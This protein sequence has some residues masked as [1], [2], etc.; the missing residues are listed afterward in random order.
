MNFNLK[1]LRATLKA[2]LLTHAE[3][4]KKTLNKRLRVLHFSK[5]PKLLEKQKK[6]LYSY[7][8]QYFYRIY[9]KTPHNTA[10][11]RNALNCIQPCLK[12]CQPRQA[13]SLAL[14]V[15]FKHQYAL[16]SKKIR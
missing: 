5:F 16:F 15:N 12:K 6:M 9:R 3:N 14:S 11:Y 4:V 13:F 10:L 1:R 2:G 8:I 7:F